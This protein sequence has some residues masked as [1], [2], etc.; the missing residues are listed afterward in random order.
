MIFIRKIRSLGPTSL[1]LALLLLPGCTAPAAPDLNVENHAISDPVFAAGYKHI[2]D[3][4]IEPVDMGEVAM[5]GLSRIS[6]IDSGL[7]V[8][9]AAG[10][11]RLIH[12]NAK[13]G[14]FTSP[15]ATDI[16]GWA[17]VTAEIITAGR[18]VSKPLSTKDD[19]AVYKAVFKGALK[20]LDGH[21]RY[22]SA[23][24]AGR[25]RAMRDGFGGIGIRLGFND[26]E[27]K[28][29][30]VME[31]T[32]AEDAGLKAND[33]ITEIDGIPAKGLSQ[34]EV[35]AH[36]RGPIDTQVEVKV[37]RQGLAKALGISITRAHIVVPTIRYARKG[38]IAHIRLTSFNHDTA[39][40]LIHA[41]EQAKDEI[42]AELKGIVLDMRNNP[43][44]LLNQA[45]A[46][47]DVF[48]T[49]GRIVSTRGRHP[50]SMQVFDAGGD[51]LAVGIPLVVLVNGHSAS[52]AEVAAAAL[53]D[54]GR[55]ILIGSNSF[56]KGTVQNITR[57][58]NGGEMIL[59]WSRLYTPSGYALHHL[60]VLPTICTSGDEQS[61]SGLI[62][63]LRQGRLRIAAAV[64]TAWRTGAGIKDERLEKLR[65]TCQANGDSSELDVKLAKR[66]LESRQLYARALK[67]TET[68][69]APIKNHPLNST[70]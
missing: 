43:G 22:A 41:I 16:N 46:V 28:V 10:K 70:H 39:H 7:N 1:M 35:V 12:G 4:Y 8:S 58:P 44:G 21:S 68:A 37:L 60:G 40:S 13:V 52:A 34:R 45:V 30:S 42:G 33:I 57:L 66:I 67:L 3:K 14:D 49:G 20:G 18:G 47:A 29:V 51:D 5:R 62:A 11:V 31:D 19:E 27:V 64:R 55:A 38:S 17:A 6:A 56:G 65:E 69:Q 36:L 25:N 50:D 32:P 23:K 59:T 48:L 2:Y 24:A 63:K 53:Q 15:D 61:V 26:G 9:R 54:Q